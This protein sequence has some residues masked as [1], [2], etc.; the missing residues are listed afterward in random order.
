MAEETAQMEALYQEAMA[1]GGKVTVW[2]DGDAASRQDAV[3]AAFEQRFPEI[4]LNLV[5]DLS[6]FHNLRIED[7]LAG[8]LELPD[9]AQLQT[10]FDYDR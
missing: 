5:V 10:T 7:A 9:V 4:E 2:A 6:K 1:A 3:V 8:E